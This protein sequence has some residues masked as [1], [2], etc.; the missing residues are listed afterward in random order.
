MKYLKKF[1]NHAGYES[2]LVG[3]EFPKTESKPTV[4]FCKL[5]NEV[6]YNKYIPYNLLDILYANT[7]GKKK[8]DSTVLDPSLGYTPIGLCIASS[9]FFGT[10][11]KARWMS[12]KY[13]NC[14]APE[15]GSL[16]AQGIFFGKN[17]DINTIDNIL[18]TYNGGP[19]WGNLTA[20]WI[21]KTENK[22]PTLFTED[23]EWNISVLGT[24]NTY[25][26][27]DIDGKNKTDKILA[28]ATAQSDWRTSTTIINNKDD[29]DYAPA[30]CCCARY[31][32]IGT[33]AGDWYLGACGEMSMITVLKPQINNKLTQ[34]ATQYPNNCIR[35][36]SNDYYWTSTE[37]GNNSIYSVN[38]NTGLINYIPKGSNIYVVAI[39]TF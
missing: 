37:Y 13:M 2:Y 1:L 29:V 3:S 25:A 7:N 10:G 19:S 31:H 8:V 24:V 14:D 35:S 21:T 20:D 32:T 39:L 23:N 11:E 4:Q 12:L 38:T 27:T 6:H 34:I 9:G 33:Q 5:Q 30:A 36:L 16:T 28:I 18:A 15:T 17:N 26:V 22:I